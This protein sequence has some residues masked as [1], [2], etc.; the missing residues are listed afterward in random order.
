VREARVREA[1][2]REARVTEQERAEAHLR[3]HEGLFFCAAC[4][5]HELGVP[6]FE[7]RNILWTL[8]ALPGFEMRGTKCVSCLRGKRTIRYVG[9]HSVI[10]APAQVV[11]FLLSNQEIYLCEACIAF[12]VEIS[13]AEVRRVVAYVAPLPEFDRREGL[14]TVCSRHTTIV[15]ARSLDDAAS[16]R[17]AQIVTGTV[18]YRGW[19]IDL[20][21][22]RTAQGWRPFV[23]IKGSRGG[24]LPDA[25]S[26]MGSVFPTKA[27]ADAEA[28][29]A[30]RTWI[31]KVSD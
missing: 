6:A 9:G 24:Q 5:A 16:D 25:P 7:G 12:A 15:T 27:E 10:G 26:V 19:R 22:Y 30:A 4:L 18:P 31:D 2:V 8:Q 13:L 21:S 1:R 17:I 29:Q 3:K 14:C 23:L 11:L 28:L 20:L